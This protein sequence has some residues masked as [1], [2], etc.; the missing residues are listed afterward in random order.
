ME[1]LLPGKGAI[2]WPGFF[3]S[4]SRVGFKGEVAVDI[5]GEEVQIENIAE[6]YRIAASWIE[7]ALILQDNGK[8]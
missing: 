7:Q 6:V 1:H 2:H 4:L 5:G 8:D 3:E